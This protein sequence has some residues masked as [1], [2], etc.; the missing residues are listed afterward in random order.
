LVQ[1]LLNLG[2]G[3][4]LAVVLGAALVR[5][6]PK[7]W[8]WNRMVLASAVGGSTQNAGVA[9]EHESSLAS[10]IG[11]TGTAVTPLRPS[12]QVEIA[13][14][15]YEARLTLGA[16]ERGERVVV[17]G[18]ADFSLTVEKSQDSALPASAAMPPSAPA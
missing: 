2:L 12:G 4:A 8:I 6:L 3:F 18:R 16:A 9:G 10:L 14:R 11:Q 13:G 1:P 17:I 5:F 15:R 7:G